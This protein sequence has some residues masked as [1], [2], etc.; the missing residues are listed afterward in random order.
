MKVFTAYPIRKNLSPEQL[1]AIESFRNL[2]EDNHFRFEPI[3]CL[4][5]GTLK[6]KLLFINDRYNLPVNVSMCKV[7]GLVHESPR[8]R[9]K[10]VAEFYS[11]DLYRDIYGGLNEN[12]E[13][14]FKFN[15]SIKLDFNAYHT[16][17]SFY[18]FIQD[19]GINY[20]S[21]CEVGAG[22]GWNLIPFINEGKVAVGYEPGERLV[23]LGQER[24]IELYRGFLNNISGA[25]DLIFLKHVLEHLLDPVDSLKTLK[26]HTKRYIAVEVPGWI[27]YVPSIQN[28][29]VFYFTLNTLQKIFALAGF[30][31]VR[32]DY[33]RKNRFIVGLFEKENE[34]NGSFSYDF[35]DELK[36]I[37]KVY[38]KS[39][40][41]MI[42]K[43]LFQLNRN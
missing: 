28:A 16:N 5:C 29:H 23:R 8:L 15:E 10:D 36:N 12:F 37:L 33:F 27:N 20:D 14:R 42:P 18:A 30:R 35:D 26:N 13:S 4:I 38:Y 32:I 6:K 24:G 9:S 1:N 21:V 31:A 17:E 43:V 22:G 25:F 19:A 3:G 11:L 2:I 34:L 7:C 41:H 39:K 40:V